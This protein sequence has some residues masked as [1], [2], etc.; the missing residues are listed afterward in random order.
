MPQGKGE[1]VKDHKGEFGGREGTDLREHI[2]VTHAFQGNW[3]PN[4]RYFRIRN[5][6]SIYVLILFFV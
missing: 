5:L 6:C 2:L 3:G 4:L 1:L